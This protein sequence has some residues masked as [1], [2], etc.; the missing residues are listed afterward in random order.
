MHAGQTPVM[1]TEQHMAK[2]SVSLLVVCR[3]YR[4]VFFSIIAIPVVPHFMKTRKLTALDRGD[5]TAGNGDRRV[6]KRDNPRRRCGVC[7]NVAISVRRP[8]CL[9]SD[10]MSDEQSFRRASLTRF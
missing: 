9:A 2:L 6:V 3:T 8:P 4:C 5:V 1:R 10:E 7:R